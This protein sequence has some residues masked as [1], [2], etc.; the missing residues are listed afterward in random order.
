MNAPGHS[1]ELFIISDLHIGG[2]HSDEP[3]GRGFRINTHVDALVHFI[4]EIG[5]RARAT[6]R[7]TELVINGDFIDFLAEEVP[8]DA[9]R[10]SF[11]ANQS[12]AVATLDAIVARDQRFLTRYAS[13][14]PAALP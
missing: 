13:C 3:G 6:G 10:R 2:K 7:R 12:E 8:T 11:I 9:R 5:A 1:A 14:S 4:G